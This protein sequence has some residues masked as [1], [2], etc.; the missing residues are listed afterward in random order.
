[1]RPSFYYIGTLG[2]YLTAAV[3]GILIKDVG[4]VFDFV[5]AINS[6]TIGFIIPGY[7]YLACESKF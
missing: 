1:M 7:Y 6:S 2:M 4:I 3:C 5:G